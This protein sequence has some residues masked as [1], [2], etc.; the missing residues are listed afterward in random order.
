MAPS[1]FTWQL[2]VEGGDVEPVELTGDASDLAH[3]RHELREA[4]S[5]AAGRFDQHDDAATAD[6]EDG[7]ELRREAPLPT[8]KAKGG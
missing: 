1:S 5:E 4:A 8:P 7:W 2:R 6:E 3:L